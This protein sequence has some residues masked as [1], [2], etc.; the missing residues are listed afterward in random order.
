[1]KKLKLEVRSTP[2]LAQ[3]DPNKKTIIS[4]DAS[5]FGIG[6]VLFQMQD[7]GQNKAVPY[8]SR[9]LRYAQVEKEALTATWASER[10]SYY[11]T[12]LH[13]TLQTDHKPLISLLGNKS[14][15]ELTPRIQRIRMRLMG[16]DYSVE[17]IPGKYIYTADA[18]SRAPISNVQ[19]SAE[20]ELQKDISLY[21]NSVMTSLPA[22]DKKLD[23]IMKAQNEDS[24]C[25][26]LKKDCV[27]GWP[28]PH[29]L[30]DEII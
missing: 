5:S 28:E 20:N 17:Y 11:V 10:F 23:E 3:Y 26:Q 21:G 2:T 29:K 15:D 9:S 1:M 22:S 18:L 24:L 4:S 16:F 30:K 13:F 12:G 8:S 6:A 19:C 27:E 25:T 7:D 14:S